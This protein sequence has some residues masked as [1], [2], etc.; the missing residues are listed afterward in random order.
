MN[1]FIYRTTLFLT[2]GFFIVLGYHYTIY[3]I[4]LCDRDYYK[5]NDNVLTVVLGDSHTETSI[6][7]ELSG[8]LQNYSYKGE[9]LFL[10]YYKLKQLLEVNPQI[11]NVLLSF[12]YHSL[13]KF[14]DDK[15]KLLLYDY[16]WLLD[17]EGFQQVKYS[18]DNLN[19]VLKD[20]NGRLYQWIISNIKQENFHLFNGGYRKRDEH[21]LSEAGSHKRIL[22]HY[23]SEDKKTTQ[24]YSALQK[25]YLNKIVQ[26]CVDKN[27]KLSFINTPLHQSYYS[28][29]PQQYI[30]KYYSH[31]NA[32]KN[33]HPGLIALLD[34]KNAMTADK[35]FHDGDH[36][37]G[38]GGKYF[39]EMLNKKLF[40]QIED[41]EPGNNHY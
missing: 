23:F 9:S 11:K 18:L 41:N 25:K 16:Y 22:K 2:L 27:L 14:Q 40:P 24:E 33:S 34:F 38:E 32:I 1:T 31:V 10:S 37:N 35:L 15:L 8:D 30:S 5:I 4:L 13:N 12:S 36:L 7:D 39:M 28:N 29:I 20:M 19:L 3:H 21:N 26:L 6:N 17:R